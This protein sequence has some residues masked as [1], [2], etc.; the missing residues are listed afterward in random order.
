[1]KTQHTPKRLELREGGNFMDLVWEGSSLKDRSLSEGT[2]AQMSTEFPFRVKRATK[3]DAKRLVLCWNTH[4]ALVDALR[5]VQKLAEDSDSDNAWWWQHR[6]GEI[7]SPILA[8]L[9]AP[10]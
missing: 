8:K 4:D 10:S 2:L 6:I 9:D 5:R 3:A 1:M 7:V